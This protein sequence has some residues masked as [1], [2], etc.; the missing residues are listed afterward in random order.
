MER[1]Y[2]TEGGGLWELLT[3]SEFAGY[4]SVPAYFVFGYNSERQERQENILHN[5][6]FDLSDADWNDDTK[7]EKYEAARNYMTQLYGEPKYEL[8]YSPDGIKLSSLQEAQASGGTASAF[9]Y[10]ITA[11]G[12]RRSIAAIDL[13]KAGIVAGVGSLLPT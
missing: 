3:A 10:L 7:Y 2:E 1:V 12:E 4:H 8:Y 9:W 6:N 11:D 5:V 13:T